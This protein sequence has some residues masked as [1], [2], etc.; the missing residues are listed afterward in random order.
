MLGFRGTQN[1]AGDSWGYIDTQT[2]MWRS[3]ARGMAVGVPVQ[4]RECDRRV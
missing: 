2:D 4:R 1:R 3:R